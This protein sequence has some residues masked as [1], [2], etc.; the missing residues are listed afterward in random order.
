M[1][2]Y[3]EWVYEYEEQLR[4]ML[5]IQTVSLPLRLVHHAS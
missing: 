2:R 3:D 1:G 4:S 5:I